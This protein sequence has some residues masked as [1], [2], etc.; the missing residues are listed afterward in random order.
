[1]GFGCILAAFVDSLYVGDAKFESKWYLQSGENLAE[2]HP[3]EF[4]DH[5]GVQVHTTCT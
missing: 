1:L 3:R 4:T 5:A 2:V